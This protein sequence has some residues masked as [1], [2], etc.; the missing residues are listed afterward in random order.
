MVSRMSTEWHSVNARL[1][2][3]M[4]LSLLMLLPAASV[5][6]AGSTYGS[7]VVPSGS[8]ICVEGTVIDHEEEP[9]DDGRIVT[10]TFNGTSIAAAVDEDG[11]FKFKKDLVPGR[12]NF[13]IDVVKDGEEWEPVTPASFDVQLDYDQDDCYEIRFK[14]RRLVTV[15]VIKI[16]EDHNRLA[17]WEIRAVPAGDNTFA[18]A[19]EAT[20][21]NNGEATFR[22]SEGDWLFYEAPPEDDE[23]LNYNPV[24]PLAG[25]QKLTV[26]E[27]GP[28]TIR[29]KNQLNV[30]GCIE[31]LKQD[32]P[33]IDSGDT[34]FPLQGWKIEVLRADDSVAVWGYTDA[35]GTI[36]F[37]DLPFGPYT[38]VEETRVGWTSYT[39]SSFDVELTPDLNGCVQVTF[40]NE[41][42]EPEYCIEGRK[43]DING[44]VGLPGWVISAEPLDDDDVDPKDVVTD[45][46]GMYEFTFSG[47]DYRVPGSRYEV[48]EDYDDVE[49]WV[50]RSPT[51]YTVTLPTTPGACVV[52]P[53]FVNA[54]VGHGVSTGHWDDDDDNCSKTHTVKRGDSLYGIGSKYGVSA[55][56]MLDANPWVRNNHKLTIYVGQKICIP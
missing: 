1:G 37:E 26:E 3:A 14:L 2:L 31:V 25:K 34:P 46:L 49:G 47:N 28:Y 24:V 43:I 35:E 10:A 21:N 52:V 27:P 22:L 11:E 32:V 56:K 45:G 7:G 12:W 16:D 48:C 29:F 38:V 15:V 33:P 42:S 39:A 54:Q 30:Y 18:I 50:A 44:K 17:D 19:Y 4:I 51:C 41:Q 20:T 23:D 36:K 9:L 55:S 40:D 5:N 53:D 8:D 13:T 6:A